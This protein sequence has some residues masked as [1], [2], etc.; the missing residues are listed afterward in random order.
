VRRRLVWLS[1]AIFLLWTATGTRL[2][3]VQVTRGPELAG[4]ALGQRAL[5]LPVG[6]QRGRILDR[7]GQDLSDGR[8]VWGVAAFPTLVAAPAATARALA[9][10]LRLS[11]SELLA[12]LAQRKPDWLAISVPEQTAAEVARMQLPG[13]VAARAWQQYGANPLARHLVGYLNEQGSQEGL[14]R[15][16]D[17][18]LHGEALSA[19]VAYQDGEERPLH[20]I[21]IRTLTLPGKEPFDVVTTVDRRIQAAVE[22]TLDRHEAEVSAE[23]TPAG[24]PLRAGVGLPL[25][26]GVV[27]L[28]PF[29]GEVLALASRPNYD[30]RDPLR[31]SEGTQLLNR[32]VIPF[33][34]GSVLK[35]LVAAE[36]LEG[37]LVRPD[38]RFRCEGSYDLGGYRPQCALHPGGH[39]LITLR[40]ALAQSCNVALIRIGYERLG[41]GGLGRM[42]MRYGFGAQ[43]GLSLWGEQKG[44]LPDLHWPYQS[45]Q[46]SFGQG[47]TATPLQVARAL[48][49]IPAGGILPP[50][51]LVKEVRAPDGTIIR[52]PERGAPVRVMEPATARAL[53]AALADVTAPDGQGT[54]RRAWVPVHG[55]AGKTGSAEGIDDGRPAVHAWFG[56]WA[57]LGRPRYVIVVMVQAGGSGGQ[58]AAPLF[59]QIAAAILS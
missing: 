12:K 41:A 5:I 23:T 28:D 3:H 46:L 2:W 36:A 19:L 43:T 56:G 17:A 55:S 31:N 45:V 58:V 10:V 51:S 48:A 1:A 4:R 16:Y 35:P 7:H 26:A 53:A 49:A 30:Q 37:G 54:G 15:V 42:L 13:V 27:V 59:R 33:E 44:W 18:S 39:G 34:P 50:L 25:R 22:A 9:P 32:A 29:S 8:P 14:Q 11:E 47:L 21:G 52:R 20:G 6:L 38:E 40:E 24:L 57:P